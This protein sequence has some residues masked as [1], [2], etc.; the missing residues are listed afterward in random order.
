M[1]LI[2]KSDVKNHL[3]LR[4]Q[5]HIHIAPVSQPDATGFSETSVEVSFTQDFTGDHTTTAT[6]A[7]PSVASIGAPKI[8][9]PFQTQAEEV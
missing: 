2:K 1:S 5:N 7:A 6:A 4:H 8:Q 9:A 3:S